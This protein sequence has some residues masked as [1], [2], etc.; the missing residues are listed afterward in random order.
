M[1]RTKP[2]QC[3]PVPR[4]E[5]APGGHRLVRHPEGGFEIAIDVQP[6]QDAE[7]D[8]IRT[9]AQHLQRLLRDVDV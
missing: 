4:I 6:V 1:K 3:P 8:G 7:R 9:L 2:P 5:P